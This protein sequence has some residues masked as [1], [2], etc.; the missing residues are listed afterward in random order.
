MVSIHSH[1]P[2]QWT[3]RF[4]QYKCFHVSPQVIKLSAEI[5]VLL[6][7]NLMLSILF[8]CFVLRY[9]ALIIYYLLL[10]WCALKYLFSVLILWYET[11]LIIWF[12]K[13]IRCLPPKY[14]PVLFLIINWWRV[15]WCF[16]VYYFYW[17]GYYKNCFKRILLIIE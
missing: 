12:E 3:S 9:S 17:L 5:A 15:K 2:Y 7:Q 13:L 11:W 10:F 8:I 16:C 6:E 14:P 1:V 4:S